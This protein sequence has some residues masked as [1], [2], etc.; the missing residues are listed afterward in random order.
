LTLHVVFLA[1]VAARQV[2]QVLL[3]CNVSVVPGAS[4]HL[5]HTAG[6]PPATAGSYTAADHHPIPKGHHHPITKGKAMRMLWEQ[7]NVTILASCGFASGTALPAGSQSSTIN[8][9]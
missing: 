3:C 4:V 2:R 8:M 9:W 7:L 6:T 5:W 1:I